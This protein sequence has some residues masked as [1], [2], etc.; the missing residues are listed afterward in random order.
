MLYPV[1]KTIAQP[2]QRIRERF[3]H[4]LSDRSRLAILDVLRDGDRTAGETAVAADLT[5]SNASRHLACLR[6]CGLV[7]ARQSWRHVYYRLA[8]GVEDFLRVVDAFVDEH[9]ERLA[10]CSRPEMDEN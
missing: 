5:P 8:D 7:E 9:A 1:A 6:D 3:F 4:G 2:D 10:S